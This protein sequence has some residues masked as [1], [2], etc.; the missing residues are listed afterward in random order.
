METSVVHRVTLHGTAETAPP[1]LAAKGSNIAKADWT[2]GGWITIGSIPAQDDDVNLDAEK[3]SIG[4]EET[5]DF[6]Q[7]VKAFAPEG[8]NVLVRAVAAWTF[9]TRDLS[10]IIEAMDSGLVITNHVGELGG[11]ISFRTACVEIDGYRL[12]YYPKVLVLSRTLGLGFG[13][14]GMAI[15]QY[16]VVPLATATVKGGFQRMWYQ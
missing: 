13:E 9:G 2:A 5:L 12:D 14:G 10:E 4:I 11:T 1:T 6:L 7:A 8:V 15:N 16:G 3:L